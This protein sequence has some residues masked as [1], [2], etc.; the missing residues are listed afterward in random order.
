[1][2]PTPVG[3]RCP[4]CSKQRT[5]VTTGT[6]SM[7]RSQVLPA[8]YALIGINVLV[9]IG[10]IISGASV[11]SGSGGTAIPD[12][13]LFKGYVADDPYRLLTSGFLHAGLPHLIFNMFALFIL[14]RLLEPAIGS[15]RFVAI[16]FAALFAGSLGVIILE[17]DTLA[18]GASGAVFGLFAAAWVV[19]RGRGFDE[20]AAQLGFLIIINLLFTF[21]VPGIAIG[22]H[23]FGALCGGVCGIAVVAGDRN[24]FGPRR[25]AAEL[26]LIVGLGLIAVVLALAIA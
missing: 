15:A 6:A 26:A 21:G 3:M 2:T 5:K 8:T 14:G 7:G 24:V 19:A 4:E 9:F 18:V 23:L 11:G 25:K 10:E 1:M 17:P 12:Y 16:Y 22:A 20:A 13:G